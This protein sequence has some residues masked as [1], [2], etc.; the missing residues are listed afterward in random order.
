MFFQGNKNPQLKSKS[1]NVL[2][3]IFNFVLYLGHIS[4]AN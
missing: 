1:L 2:I 4:K 3:E